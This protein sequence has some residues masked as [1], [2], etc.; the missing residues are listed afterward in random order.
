M[1]VAQS[2]Q[3]GRSCT[4]DPHIL[5]PTI[6]KLSTEHK[7]W[8]CLFLW[9]NVV[10]VQ[11][12]SICYNS[13]KDSR[14]L[15]GFSYWT[16]KR[17]R[18]KKTQLF[19]WVFLL[20][21]KLRI[22]ATRDTGAALP[23]HCNKVT[24]DVVLFWSVLASVLRWNALHQQGW[25]ELHCW[26]MSCDFVFTAQCQQSKQRGLQSSLLFRFLPH[27]GNRCFKFSQPIKKNVSHCWK[28]LLVLVNFLF[29]FWISIYIFVFQS[30]SSF[31]VILIFYEK[32]IGLTKFE[33]HK[34]CWILLSLMNY[35]FSVLL[36]FPGLE[37]IKE[38]S[39]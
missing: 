37:S 11:H 1:L 34:E 15:L 39:A 35:L 24:L 36:I 10:L 2:L 28:R 14:V 26:G 30:T 27:L 4:P 6:V 22:L 18:F 38:V 16:N 23:Q 29:G 25:I 19:G 33:P 5:F 3:A 13:W 7:N 31:K 12:T 17:V 32:L 8:F 20:I 9:N 21:K